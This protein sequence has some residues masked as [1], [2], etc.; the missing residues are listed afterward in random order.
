MIKGNVGTM[1]GRHALSGYRRRCCGV[2]RWA[3]LDLIGEQWGSHNPYV[4]YGQVCMQIYRA[5]GVAVCVGCVSLF[6]VLLV[7]RE[8]QLVERGQRGVR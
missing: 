2:R 5:S 4:D 7:V 3:P 6:R 8:A 1:W